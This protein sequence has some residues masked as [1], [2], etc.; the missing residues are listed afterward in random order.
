MCHRA[1]CWLNQPHVHP[2]YPGLWC[3]G[4]LLPTMTS[5]S[6]VCHMAKDS[7]HVIIVMDPKVGGPSW[8]VRAQSNHLIRGSK[9]VSHL[10]SPRD[11]ASDRSERLGCVESRGSEPCRSRRT[12]IQ[13][14]PCS[15]TLNLAIRSRSRGQPSPVACY[16]HPCKE[17]HFCFAS[18]YRGLDTG[19]HACKGTALPR[20]YGSAL[21]ILSQG[22]EV[23]WP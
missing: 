2:R 20:S 21:F 4:L 10:A 5:I 11:D 3:P 12:H 7:V 16:S 23:G 22:L 8:I 6:T 15:G 18:Q 13:T 17:M 9:A 1:G 19:L 14:Q